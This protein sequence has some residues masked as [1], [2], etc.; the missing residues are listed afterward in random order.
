[1]GASNVYV[2]MWDYY[3][4]RRVETVFSRGEDVA[5]KQKINTSNYLTKT[6]G[7]GNLMHEVCI[8][9]TGYFEHGNI[10]SETTGRSRY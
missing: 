5:T 9:H 2:C 6:P 7:N 8:S 10:K 1:M 4:I 3:Y